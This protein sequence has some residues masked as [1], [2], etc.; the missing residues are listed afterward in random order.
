[1]NSEQEFL[2]DWV[3]PPGETIVDIL[4]EREL[5]ELEFARRMY[6][7]IGE[8]KELISGRVAIT[9]GVARQLEE[10]L[11]ASV[12]FWMARDYQYRAD[13]QRI[14]AQQEEW[15]SKLPI[16]DMFKFGWLPPKEEVADRVAA[17]LDFFNVA[18]ISA[19]Q[20]KYGT[21][22]QGVA[23]RTSRTFSPQQGAV[24]AWLRRGEIEADEIDCNTWNAEGFRNCLSE[25]RT[26]SREKDPARFLPVLQ[27]LGAQNGVAIAI[28]RGPTGCRASG[29]A[30]FSSPTKAVLLLSFRHLMDDHFWFTFFHEAGHL[31]LHGA[32][33]RFVDGV[34]ESQS[35]AE[36][37]ANQFAADLL[38]PAEY[39]PELARLPLEPRSIIGFARRI[40]ISPGIVVGQLQ[41]SG[42]LRHSQMNGLKRRFTWED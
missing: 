5:S 7:P 32:D 41:N 16:A 35:A 15:V 9:L 38:I 26:L 14:K 4:K 23:F 17:C 20:A 6:R 11:G 40:G 8:V 33:N 2:P 39:R 10:V 34:D 24:A 36:Y 12:E 25:V 29:A 28:V 21:P 13:S 27:G 3:S 31:L 18:S 19:W 42:R 1:M 30:W 37:E 22:A